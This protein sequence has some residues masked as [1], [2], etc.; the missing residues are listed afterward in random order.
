MTGG[1][2]TWNPTSGGAAFYIT[3]TT[4]KI[5][6]TNATINNGSSVLLKAEANS[7]WGTSGSNGGKVT[8]TA[9]G[10]TLT[11]SISIDSISTAAITL[12]NSSTLTG[13]INSADTAKSVTLTM[14]SSSTWSVSA[15]S[16]LSYLNLDSSSISGTSISNITG[17]G[18]T[19]YYVSAN[20]NAL[21]GATYTLSGGGYL[22]P[23]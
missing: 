2:Y 14:D 3:N 18:Y 22:K 9:S 4:A 11:G 6:L 1:S 13:A 8:F 20:N 16:Y 19:V 21:G 15:D 5:T 17:N 23:M 12:G 7:N 10:E